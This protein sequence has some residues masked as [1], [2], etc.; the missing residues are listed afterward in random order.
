MLLNPQDHSFDLAFFVEVAGARVVEISEPF[1]LE[2]GDVVF[3]RPAFDLRGDGA[4][5]VVAVEDGEIRA[6]APGY[7]PSRKREVRVIDRSSVPD[8]IDVFADPVRIPLP[9]NRAV[10][11]VEVEDEG[12]LAVEDQRPSGSTRPPS[13]VPRPRGR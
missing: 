7:M 1:S 12:T 11:R 2:G 4:V 3:G 10:L 6:L 9:P 8:R 5:F 13:S